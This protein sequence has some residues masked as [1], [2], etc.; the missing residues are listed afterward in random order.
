LFEPEQQLIHSPAVGADAIAVFARCATP[1]WARQFQMKLDEM[2]VMP[3]SQMASPW[4][5]QKPPPQ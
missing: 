5:C 4:G 1:T 3:P 2:P